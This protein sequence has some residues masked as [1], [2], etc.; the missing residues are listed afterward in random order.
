MKTIYMDYHATTP[1]DTKVVEAM[2]PY[3]TDVYANS[4]GS[5][6]MAWQAKEALEAARKR[7]ADILRAKAEEI[8]FTASATEANNWLFYFLSENYA[9]RDAYRIITTPIEHKSVLKAA[10][11]HAKN[12]EVELVKVDANGI[13]DLEDLSSRIKK[14]GTLLVSIMH[15]NNEIG[16][17]Q[18]LEAIGNLCRDNQCFFH[19]DA[20]QTFA[21]YDIDVSQMPIDFLTWSAHKFYGPKGIG[22]LYARD[23]VQLKAML[24]GGAHE[25]GFRASTS[26]VA[27]AVGMAEA[28]DL[29]FSQKQEEQK[30]IA[31]LRDELQS[32]LESICQEY[33]IEYKINNASGPRLHNNLSLSFGNRSLADMQSE[34]RPICYST[35][36]ACSSGNGEIS[37]VLKAIGLEEHYA[38]NTMRLSLG[39]MTTAEEIQ[40]ALS[41]FRGALSK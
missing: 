10:K 19:S 26:N 18:D 34:L 37:H 9:D 6:A 21:K 28:A 1:C 23:S 16:S 38:R 4:S 8:Y 22:A 13:V 14:P 7:Q 15:A 33:G 11:H 2:L 35:G 30:K 36:S 32:G 40:E 24:V 5:H 12:C 3:F 25:Q 27:A 31:A 39:R 41:I 29:C 17:L 20:V